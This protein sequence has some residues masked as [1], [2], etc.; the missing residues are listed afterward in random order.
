M[1]VHEYLDTLADCTESVVATGTSSATITMNDAMARCLRDIRKAHDAG[2][3]IR[4]VGNGGSASVT[5]HLEIDLL[6]A[7]IRASSHQA[8]SSI[9]AFA[10]DDGYPQ[11]YAAQLAVSLHKHDIL[12]AISSSG[13]SDNIIAAAELAHERGAKVITCSG[14]EPSNTLRRLGYVN[15]YVPSGQYGFVELT[16]A[17]LLHYLTDALADA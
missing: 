12:V 13:M 7:G 1:T 8:P 9:T 17:A 11:S 3:T 6:K 15:F 2:G 14:F 4:A 5:A 10:N 16:H